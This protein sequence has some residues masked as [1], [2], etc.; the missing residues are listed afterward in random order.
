MRRRN[1]LAGLATTAAS[2]VFGAAPATARPALAGLEDL[3]LHRG[4]PA[5]VVAPCE[6]PGSGISITLPLL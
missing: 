3:L 6:K 4:G 1:L 2:T 5:K